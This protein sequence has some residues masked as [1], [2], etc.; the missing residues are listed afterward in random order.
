MLFWNHSKTNGSAFARV[1]EHDAAI[2]EAKGKI[3]ALEAVNEATDKA[4]TELEDASERIHSMRDGLQARIHEL[5][6][7]L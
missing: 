3:V 1:A 6:D 2:L 5:Q 7:S 4:L